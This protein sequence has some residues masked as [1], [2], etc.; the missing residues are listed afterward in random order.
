MIKK[1]KYSI[2]YPIIHDFS[3]DR[4]WVG[5]G[6]I[7][8]TIQVCNRRWV[9]AKTIRIE[10]TGNAAMWTGSQRIGKKIRRKQVLWDE[11]Y[12]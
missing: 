10:E 8:W 4:R 2:S 5:M 11:H 3:G 1:L 9:Y 6:I 12:Y 7:G